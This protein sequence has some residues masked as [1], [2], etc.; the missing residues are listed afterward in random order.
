MSVHG[1]FAQRLPQAADLLPQFD[2]APSI[3]PYRARGNREVFCRYPQGASIFDNKRV[4]Q[5]ELD[6]EASNFRP[7][8]ARTK[9]QRNVEFEQPVD[10]WLAGLVTIVVLIQQRAV[11]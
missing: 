11:E 3:R 1:G 2:H 10:R 6:P 5:T 8:L 7:R 4:A 9:N